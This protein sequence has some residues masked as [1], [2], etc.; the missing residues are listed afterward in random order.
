MENSVTNENNN[1]DIDAMMQEGGKPMTEDEVFRSMKIDQGLVR[2]RISSA[3]LVNVIC[4]VSPFRLIY[5]L[6]GGCCASN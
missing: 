2:S 4:A 3:P 1:F 6:L 5:L